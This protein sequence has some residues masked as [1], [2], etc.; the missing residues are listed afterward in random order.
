MQMGRLIMTEQE[1]FNA[2]AQIRLT[3]QDTKFELFMYELQQ[4]REDIRRRRN[5]LVSNFNVE[6]M[7]GSD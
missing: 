6:L 7:K 1:K 5:Y 2:G 3:R 4:Q